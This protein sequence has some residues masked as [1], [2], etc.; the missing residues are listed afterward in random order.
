MSSNPSGV[1]RSPLDRLAEEFVDRHRRGERPSLAE[2]TDKYPDWADE[3]RDLFPALVVIEQLKPEGADPTISV[4]GKATTGTAPGRRPERLGDYRILREVGQGGMGIVYEA[5]QESLGR[6]VALKVLPFHGR[7]KPSHLERFRLEARSAARLHHTN[8]VPVFGVGEHDGVHYYAMQFIQGQ[9]LDQVLHDLRRLR[10]PAADKAEPPVADQTPSLALARGLLTGSLTAGPVPPAES[11]TEPASGFRAHEPSVDF[12]LAEPKP[13]PEVASPSGG[14]RSELTSQSDARYYRSVAAIGAQ[15]AEALAHAHGQGVLHRDVKPSNLLLD[16]DGHVWVTDFGLAKVEG[17]DGLTLTG[18]VVGTVRYMAP[19]RFE[20]WSDP[21]SDLYGLGLTLYELLTLRPAF[22]GDDRARLI[23]RILHVPPTPP[24]RLDPRVPRDLE[25]IVLKAIAK[26]PADRYGSAQA[27]ADDLRRFLDDRPVLARRVRLPERAWRWCRRNPALATMAALVLMLL[28]VVAVGSSAAALWLRASNQQVVGLLNRA[29]TARKQAKAAEDRMT[30]QLVEALQ[31]RAHASRL[32]AQAG[33]RFDSL[34]A[35]AQAAQTRRAAELRNQAIV[36]PA[37]ADLRNEAIAAL[38]LADLRPGRALAARTAESWAI[39][40]DPFLERYAV[41][42][43]GG[44]VRILRV[45]DDREVARLPGS[46]HEVRSLLFS[47]D[48][49]FLAAHYW[50]G[51]PGSEFR[52]WDLDGPGAPAGVTIGNVFAFWPRTNFTFSPDGRRLAAAL[53]DN[54]IGLF[55]SR[56]GALLRRLQKV[57]RPDHMSFHPDG[58]RLAIT[59]VFGNF[60]QVLDVERDRIVWKYDVKIHTRGLAWRGDGRLLAAG[61]DDQRIYVWDMADMAVTK[62]SE[63]LLT[64]LA[65]QPHSAVAMA[66]TRSGDMLLSSA[67]DGTTIAWDPVRGV[68][69]ITTRGRLVRVGADDRGVGILEGEDQPRVWELAIGRECRVLPERLLGQRARRPYG[70]SPLGLDFHPDGRLLASAGSDGVRLW[71]VATRAE[72]A[73]L[74]AREGECTLFSPDGSRLLTFGAPSG[75]E[76]VSDLRI[77]PLG[78]DPRS[79]DGGLLVGPPRVF[80][81]PDGGG[82]GRRASWH[83]SG[84]SLAIIHT[85]DRRVV[86]LDLDSGSDGLK[87]DPIPGMR[88]VSVSP[89]GRWVVASAYRASDIKVWSLADGKLAW[90]RPCGSAV[91]AF[92]PDGRWLA[93]AEGFHYRLWRVGTWQP[94]PVI[95]H[96]ERD[97]GAMAFSADGAVLALESGGRVRLVDPETGREI[98]TLEPPAHVAGT[99]HALAFSRDGRHLAA[100]NGDYAILLWDLPLVRQGLARLGLDWDLP[101]SPTPDPGAQ[102]EAE[103]ATALRIRV[104]PEPWTTYAAR[105]EQEGK[106]GKWNDAAADFA[107][108]TDLGADD[109]TAWSRHL[110][111]R[112]WVGDPAGYRR[113]CA[114]LADL[115][116]FRRP[117]DGR[118]ENDLAWARVIGPDS[119]A[120]LAPVARALESLLAREPNHYAAQNTLGCVLYR[121]GRYA[122]S[123]RRLDESLRL[124]GRQGTFYDWLFL[125]MAHHGL[126]HPAEARAWLDRS[127][128]WLDQADRGAIRSDPFLTLPLAWDVRLQ[129]LILLREAERLIGSPM[130]EWPEDAFAPGR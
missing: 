104:E 19:E 57:P 35:L 60:V 82:D 86:M 56:T 40:F 4:A 125:A 34:G 122:E 15:V 72:L 37:L 123:V 22:E 52:I 114:A 87:L 75:K 51:R 49:R 46:G 93:T 38:A 14:D 64:V 25:T 63:S 26:E 53:G 54:S 31:A 50:H 47:P 9:G 36:A 30:G 115:P 118:A 81:P 67:W 8:I 1:D 12:A 32:S 65:G 101:T 17:S 21:R 76:A 128:H 44:S 61:G 90:H 16:A 13:G 11:P 105:G 28:V 39:D 5:V 92:S 69:L 20:G 66:F 3:I 70:W 113:G 119:G 110:Y 23:D 6:H 73:H 2:Y 127:K 84:R 106:A 77:W 41:G 10:G 89:D 116:S 88:Y 117:R 59:T 78:P 97:Y 24:R 95:P 27:M 120:D 121:L 29:E 103:S 126:G 58:V 79:A 112:L 91:V 99:A 55:D 129:A 102:G 45:A 107:R 7:V 100:S 130:P 42:E 124:H 109:T 33:R 111:L 108:A 96:P 80:A 71:D 43:P 62:P 18:D 98:A 68:P 83:P 85:K 48:G 74:P 94:G